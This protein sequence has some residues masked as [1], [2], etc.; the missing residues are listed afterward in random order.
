MIANPGRLMRRTSVI[1]VLVASVISIAMGASGCSVLD[2]PER[3]A[4]QRC[5]SLARAEMKNLSG[6]PRYRK[7]ASSVTLEESGGDRTFYTI[8]GEYFYRDIYG[9]E[10]ELR[11]TCSVAKDV[12]ASSWRTVDF[13]VD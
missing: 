1:R 8:R 12:G 11:F 9:G 2:N 7:A 5:Q 4:L 13:Q 6:N 10:N 3:Q